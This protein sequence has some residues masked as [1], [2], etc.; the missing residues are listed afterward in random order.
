MI[1]HMT[2]PKNENEVD[3]SLG[4]LVAMTSQTNLVALDK[5]LAAI[6]NAPSSYAAAAAKAGSIGERILCAVYEINLIL[7]PKG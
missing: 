2:A 5:T 1:T 4:R 7:N 3:E 6:R